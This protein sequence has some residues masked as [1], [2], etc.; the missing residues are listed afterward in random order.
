MSNYTHL[1]IYVDENTSKKD[2]EVDLI[3]GLL[4]F[5]ITN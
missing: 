1:T 3:A 2:V 5:F 4:R